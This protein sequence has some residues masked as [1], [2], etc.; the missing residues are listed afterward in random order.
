M[1]LKQIIVSEKCM[2]Q[3]SNKAYWIYSY[4]D[5]KKKKRKFNF[6]SAKKQQFSKSKWLSI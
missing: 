1:N 2:Q 3:K 4:M 5:L 6:P